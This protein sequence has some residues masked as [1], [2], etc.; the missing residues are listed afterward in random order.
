MG[1]RKLNVRRTNVTLPTEV[2]DKIDFYIND[3]VTG[4]PR[5]GALS[6]ILAS[7]LQSLI[8]ELEQPGKDPIKILA[9]LGVNLREFSSTEPEK[10]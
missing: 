2:A 3:P 1:R 9:G 7:L 4:K 10:D 8:R 5:Y 6:A